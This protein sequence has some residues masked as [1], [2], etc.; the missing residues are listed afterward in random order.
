ME[1]TKEGSVRLAKNGNGRL[2][3]ILTSESVEVV[4][5]LVSANEVG[6]GNISWLPARIRHRLGFARDWLV[7]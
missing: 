4:V 6:G 5:P 7:I 1:R 2:S 3:S